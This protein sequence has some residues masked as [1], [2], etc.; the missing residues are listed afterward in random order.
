MNKK[1]FRTLGVAHL[2]NGKPINHVYDEDLLKGTKTYV[3]STNSP[4]VARTATRSLSRPRH[5]ILTVD[6]PLAPLK[7]IKLIKL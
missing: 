6:K 7:E 1:S 5:R 3:G 4:W 2:C